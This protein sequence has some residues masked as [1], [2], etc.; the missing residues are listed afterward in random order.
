MI[1][2]K[3]NKQDGKKIFDLIKRSEPLD[4]NSE[5]LYLLQST[6]FS[7]Y[8]C[9]VSNE[10]KIVG[11]VSGYMHPE[12]EN[13][14]FV[15]QVAVDSSCRGK[16]LAV[17][18]IEHILKR[19]CLQGVDT[20]HTTISPSNKSSQKVFEKIA[21]QYGASIETSTFLEVTDFNDA[22]EDEVLYSI[23]PIKI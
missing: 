22:H 6:H 2:R 15:W 4:L 16:G 3:P 19:S 12:H 5:Y 18:M 21:N 7:N 14:Y 17:R 9:V 20:I 13:V 10:D 1:F 8:C 11:F 23:H